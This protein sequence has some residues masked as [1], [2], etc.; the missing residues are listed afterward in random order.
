MY[1][2]II[3][4]KE[5]CNRISEGR[6]AQIILTDDPDGDIDAILQRLKDGESWVSSLGI[7]YRHRKDGLLTKAIRRETTEKREGR[8][9]IISIVPPCFVDMKLHGR[10]KSYRTTIQKIYNMAAKDE[11]ARLRAEAKE[12]RK[13]KAA[14][15]SK[16]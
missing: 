7:C 11:A 15:R 9:I 1:Y 2:S 16:P 10:R 4:E 12:K 5:I 6:L 14:L 3:P 8:A 13:A